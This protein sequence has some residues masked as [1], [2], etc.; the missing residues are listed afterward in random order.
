MCK[1][2]YQLLVDVLELWK[3]G[4]PFRRGLTTT[5]T[6]KKCEHQSQIGRQIC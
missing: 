6:N 5:I 3:G 1:K 4:F 2:E